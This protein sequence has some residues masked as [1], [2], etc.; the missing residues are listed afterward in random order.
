MKHNKKSLRQIFSISIVGFSTVCVLITG[1]YL[2]SRYYYHSRNQMLESTYTITEAFAWEIDNTLSFYEHF[3][4]QLAHNIE[5]ELSSQ[6]AFSYESLKLALREIPTFRSLKVLDTSLKV[7]TVV[8][9]ERELMGVDYSGHAFIKASLCEKV[10]WSEVYT[11]PRTGVPLISIPIPFELGV[12]VADLDLWVFQ[13]MIKAKRLPAN[14]H[15]IILD[16]RGSVVAHPEVSVVEQRINL[17]NEDVVSKVTEEREISGEFHLQGKPYLGKAKRLSIN[18]WIV[19]VGYPREEAL[20]PIWKSVGVLIGLIVVITLLAGGIASIWAKRLSKPL[21]GILDITQ[22][23]KGG[24]LNIEKMECD[25]EETQSIFYALHSMAVAIREREEEL[26]KSEMKY[27]DLVENAVDPIIILDLE[28]RILEVNRAF[29]IKGYQKEEVIGRHITEFMAEENR[30]LFQEAKKK[31]LK[32][33]SHQFEVKTPPKEGAKRWYSVSVR[34]LLDKDL[35]VTSVQCI[36]RDITALKEYESRLKESEEKYRSLYNSISDIIYTQ[37]LEGRI[38]S[39]NKALSRLFGYEPH[40]V[41][42][43]KVSELMMPEFKEA[44]ETEYLERLKKEKELEGITKYFTKDQRKIYVKWKSKL[45]EPL[46]SEPFITGIGMDVTETILAQRRLKQSEES[47][48]A[49]FQTA[50]IPIAVYDSEGRIVAINHAFTDVFGWTEKEAKGKKLPPAPEDEI[51][52]IREEQKKTI[53]MGNI[54]KLR[55]HRYTKDRKLLDVES[56]ASALVDS[57]KKLKLLVVAFNDIT[58]HKKLERALQHAEKM[59][60]IGTLAAGIAH[61]FNNILMGIQGNMEL[62]K[63]KLEKESPHQNRI[64]TVLKLVHDAS[65]LTKQMLGLARA[66]KYEVK[67]TN[68]NSVIREYNRVFTQS[69]KDVEILEDLAEDLW[70]INCDRNQMTQ[71][72]TNLYINAV[73]AI[74]EKLSAQGIPMGNKRISVSTRNV[75]LDQKELGDFQASSGDFVKLTVTDEGIGMDENLKKRIFEPFFTTK[76]MGRG[77][78]LGLASVYGIVKNHGG[79]IAVESYPGKGTSFY[80]YLPRAHAEPHKE[81]EAREGHLQKGTAKILLVDDEELV[82]EALREILIELGYRVVGTS[83]PEEA[84]KIYEREGA[85]IDLVIVDMIMPKMSGIELIQIIRRRD[86]HA[87]IL[88]SSGYGIEEQ[89]EALGDMGVSGVIQKPFSIQSV[90]EV[91]GRV[92]VS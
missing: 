64:Q 81:S 87:K 71:V 24:N 27:R 79:H 28:G 91:V 31:I 86:P 76:G 6:N 42:G 36:A 25:Y 30:Y 56:Y 52:R 60:A 57:N 37:D 33:E 18:G 47:L 10:S 67:A 4:R 54:Q 32:G 38:I 19:L 11:C 66:G 51:E 82:L 84:I 65:T 78:G 9:I 29:L 39:C 34:P 62:L 12:L 21:K 1:V 85:Q 23:I 72:L 20:R 5:I 63:M 70:T 40:E 55:G 88:V 26:I 80:I 14:L 35:N 46:N 69:R 73:H 2:L 44:F 8:P 3:V 75:H 74:E 61:N 17:S 49:I 58:E 43:K 22:G 59:E 13:Q 16:H 15:V 92:L 68:L 77:T 41:I 83:D 90:S 50:P 7:R 45:V 89:G 48:R 53:E